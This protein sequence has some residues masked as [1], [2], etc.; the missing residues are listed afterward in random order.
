MAMLP[1]NVSLPASPH[2][3]ALGSEPLASSR[4]S[5][6]S[7]PRPCISISVVLVTVDGPPA[8]GTAPPLTTMVPPAS[9]PTTMVFLSS[10][11]LTIKTPSTHR[12]Q[13]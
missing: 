9:L 2:I 5:W 6:S 10:S 8:I 12:R 11:P 13:R 7:L 1:V 4:T 3:R